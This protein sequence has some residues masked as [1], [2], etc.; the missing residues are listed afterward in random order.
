MKAGHAMV[1][2]FYVSCPHC[3]APLMDPSTG[4]HMIGRD[5]VDALRRASGTS[6]GPLVVECFECNRR[7]RLP[8]AVL[9]L[10]S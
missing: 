8:S 2:A 5:S 9:G 4:S 10:A 6:T 3:D 1:S 7:F